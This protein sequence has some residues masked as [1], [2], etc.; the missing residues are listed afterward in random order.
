MAIM[1]PS[2]IAV[3]LTSATTVS[4]VGASSA[5]IGLAAIVTASAA[6]RKVVNFAILTV[7]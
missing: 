1:W 4:R 6:P 3:P 7:S 5:R 2:V